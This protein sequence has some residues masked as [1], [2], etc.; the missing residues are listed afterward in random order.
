M[1]ILAAVYFVLVLGL[2]V[3]NFRLA[4]AGLFLVLPA[5]L[6]RFDAFGLPTTLLEITFGAVF[7]AWLFQYARSD[8]P[9]IW[10]QMKN[11]RLRSAAF[12]VFFLA[13]VASVLVSDMVLKS[14]GQWRAYFL[15]PMLLF[16]IVV[17]RR[18]KTRELIW[19]LLLSTI[20][21][22]ALAV[23]QKF[24]GTMFAPE[25]WDDELFGRVTS[26]FTTPNAVGLYLAPVMIAAASF[27]KTETGGRKKI[28]A[29][30]LILDLLALVFS[31]SAGSLVGLLAGLVVLGWWAGYKKVAAIAAAIMLLAAFL[32]PAVRPVVTFQDRAGQNRLLLWQYTGEFLTASPKNFVLGAGI[33]QF[34]RKVQKP[35][36]DVKEL[37]RLIYPHNI[38]LNFWTETGLFGLT[39]FLVLIGGAVYH[40]KKR[41]AALL[42]AGLAGAFAVIA[43]HGLVDVP[44]FK[45]D[46]AFIFWILMAAAYV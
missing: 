23:W 13:S 43:A 8:W 20:S 27:L 32:I 35:H 45:N 37:E 42:A 19:W 11:H 30:I 46:L 39:A 34:F 18:I 7:L 33:R 31:R 1:V 9:V 6:I 40:L 24:F 12:A 25:L 41:P 21:V 22:S 29:A 10:A 26:F 44:Y 38:F 36:Y 4:L 28:V 5:Y 15:E 16:L 14:A 3:K 17:G 2:S